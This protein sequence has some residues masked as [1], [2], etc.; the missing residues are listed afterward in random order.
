MVGVHRRVCG[1]AP[2]GCVVSFGQG[3][4]IIVHEPPRQS[5]V[6]HP[7]VGFCT[8]KLSLQ[9]H[10]VG[11]FHIPM[12]VPSF[13]HSAERLHKAQA[14]DTHVFHAALA[15]AAEPTVSF[16]SQ[17]RQV[18]PQ[19]LHLDVEV[20]SVRPGVQHLADTATV[21]KLPQH[22]GLCTNTSFLPSLLELYGKPLVFLGEEVLHL[23]HLGKLPF[24][25]LA[26]HAPAIH[27][28]PL[29]KLLFCLE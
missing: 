29:P 6:N 27:M 7:E 8:V 26:N 24:S 15:I 13:V 20:F 16:A 14:N 23:I 2:E 17:L 9:S 10:K 4:P 3:L 25:Y 21:L 11:W 19:Q 1:R 22:L 28:E 12:D 5:E 18:H